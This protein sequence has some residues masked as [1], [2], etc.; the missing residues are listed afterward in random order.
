MPAG[1]SHA[2]A[3]PYGPIPEL[4]VSGI[5][6]SPTSTWNDYM[7]VG[8]LAPGVVSSQVEAA[9][10][11]VSAGI[12]E[13]H[14][15]LRGWRV[16]LRSLRTQASGDAR[17][18]LLVLMGSVS[19]VLLIA[20]ANVANLLL[21][22]GALRASELAVRT[23]LGA[24]RARLFRQLLTESLLLAAVGGGLGVLLA[25]GLR[26]TLV[27]LAPPYLVQSAPGLASGAP[28]G[29]VLGFALLA[30]LGTTLLFGAGPALQGARQE[31]AATLK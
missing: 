23:A 8:R 31:A 7:A 1:F 10:D 15:D 27:A 14:P 3:S 12:G 6:L 16:E 4:W 13:A 20:C 21:A 30:T 5:G 18:A 9:L 28:D 22:R 19:F 29:R 17:P 11:P 24:S 25:A 2:Y 26:R